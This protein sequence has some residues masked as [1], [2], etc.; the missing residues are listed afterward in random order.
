MEIDADRVCAELTARIDDALQ[1]SIL[2][3]SRGDQMNGQNVAFNQNI[4]DRQ[5]SALKKQSQQ[6]MDARA[7]LNYV[8]QTRGQTGSFVQ[9]LARSIENDDIALK[10]ADVRM[11]ELTDAEIDRRALY[12]DSGVYNFRFT[13][14]SLLDELTRCRTFNRPVTLMVVSIKN[15]EF[16]STTYGALALESVLLMSAELLIDCCRPVDLVGRF[17]EDRFIVILPETD[18]QT[19]I[20]I[21]ENIGL[22]FGRAVLQHQHTINWQ[23]NIGL[24]QFPYHG[25]DAE[26]LLALADIAADELDSKAGGIVIA[27]KL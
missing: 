7:A 11:R 13:L 26:S 5:V 18:L 14:R 27:P 1:E 4:F 22:R 2:Q 20:P 15:Q 23:A 12:D 17:M 6:N 19:A 16:I 9:S 21:A 3:S 8:R 10:R 25:Y 24:A